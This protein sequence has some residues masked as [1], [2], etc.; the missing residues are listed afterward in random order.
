[1]KDMIHTTEISRQRILENLSSAVLLFDRWL[2]LQYMNPAAEMLFEVSFRHM[3]GNPAESLIQ[4]PE[5]VTR[6]HL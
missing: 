6:Q 4:C 5:G 3:L 1:M 2:C